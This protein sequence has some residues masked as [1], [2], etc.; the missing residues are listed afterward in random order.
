MNDNIQEKLDFIATC[1][2]KQEDN[3]QTLKE[4]F[5]EQEKNLQ[6]LKNAFNEII[7]LTHKKEDTHN[8]TESLDFDE[9]TVFKKIYLLYTRYRSLRFSAKEQNI[10][11]SHLARYSTFGRAYK[12]CEYY[13]T[14]ENPTTLYT[15]FKNYW[16][17]GDCLL[18]TYCSKEKPKCHVNFEKIPTFIKLLNSSDEITNEMLDK[19]ILDDMKMHKEDVVRLKG[20]SD[21]VNL[22]SL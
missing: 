9:E 22:M 10:S 1:I 5:E 2:K 7:L 13:C 8:A 4:T 14:N 11:M 3:L 18:H 17:Y 6:T 12:L 21:F 19:V 16:Y 15:L 20:Y